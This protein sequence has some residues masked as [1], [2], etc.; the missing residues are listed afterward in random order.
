MLDD[1]SARGRAESE[2]PM[3]SELA[4]WIAELRERVASGS[5]NQ[6]EPIDLGYGTADWPAEHTVRIMLEHFDLD[7]ANPFW[8]GTF[9]RTGFI[10]R[11]MFW[12][13][14]GDCHTVH[15]FYPNIP[16]YRIPRALRL[17]RPILQREGVYEHRSLRPLLRNWFSGSRAHWSV[18]GQAVAPK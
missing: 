17:I 5:L 3:T 7:R 8:V 18:P 4:A 6:F 13:N 15:H 14:A 10:T 12:W 2:R 1:F 11:P 9:Y 16:F